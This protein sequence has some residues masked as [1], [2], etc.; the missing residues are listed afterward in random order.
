VTLRVAALQYDIA[1]EDRSANWQ[2][3]RNGV[4][5]A[6]DQGARLVVLPEMFASGF[7]MN[8]AIIGEPL[9][10]PSSAFL[11]EVAQEHGIWIGGSIA[12]RDQ[13]QARPHNRFVLAA[14]DG[15]TH[16]YAK[17]HLFSFGGEDGHYE[18]GN[19]PTVVDVEGLRCS[20]HVCYDLRFGTDFWPLATG[21]DCH[22]VIAN[23]PRPREAHWRDLLV[24]R[25]IENQAWVVGVNRV[26]VGG[27]LDY[28][29]GSAIIDPFGVTVARARE[30][31]ALLVA[32][33]DADRV[34]E[35]RKRWPFVTDRAAAR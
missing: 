5:G 14:P 33:L 8:T 34:S 25:A 12:E 23:W 29:G 31:S 10:G 35:V 16:R 4:V 6:V 22:L 1:W 7:S 18:P 20:L 15:T 19:A 21:V 13:G 11:R 30:S 27:K 26:G 9:D 24:A 2:Q 32:D 17:R 28:A 3:V